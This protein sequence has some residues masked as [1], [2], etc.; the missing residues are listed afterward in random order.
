MV[1]FIHRATNALYL[2]A[3]GGIVE[4]P[5]NGEI[6]ASANHLVHELLGACADRLRPLHFRVDSAHRLRVRQRH[7]DSV[8]ESFVAFF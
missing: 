8:V 7:S 1:I 3:Q 6:I 2:A 4:S 5:V